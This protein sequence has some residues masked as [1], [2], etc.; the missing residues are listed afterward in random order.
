MYI[1]TRKSLS[2]R[3]VLKQEGIAMGL[4]FLDAMN[5]AFGASNPAKPKRFVAVSLSLGLHN[6]FLVS[7]NFGAS[8]TQQ[9]SSLARRDR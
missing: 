8:Y 4:P 7:K 5:L 9:C 6:P 2:C 3:A 1:S